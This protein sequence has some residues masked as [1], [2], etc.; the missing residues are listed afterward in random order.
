MIN[1]AEY[2]DSRTATVSDAQGNLTHNPET[3]TDISNRDFE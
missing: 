3:V 1:D 2:Y